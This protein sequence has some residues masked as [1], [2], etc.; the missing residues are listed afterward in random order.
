[1]EQYVRRD[2]L[3]LR[4]VYPSLKT[5]I[6]EVAPDRFLIYVQNPVKDR[7]ALCKEFNHSIRFIISPV[8]LTFELPKQFVREIPIIEDSQI[9]D[10]FAGIG[11]TANQLYNLLYSKFPFLNSVK[12]DEV[13]NGIVKIHFPYDMSGLYNSQLTFF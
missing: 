9:G 7:D 13:E 12:I 2:D 4:S 11:W 5:R 1:M 3:K 8:G 10:S 6:F